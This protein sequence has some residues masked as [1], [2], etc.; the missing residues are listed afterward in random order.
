[1]DIKTP[2]IT[3]YLKNIANYD[4]NKIQVLK[5]VNGIFKWVDE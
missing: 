1:M 2:H 3:A 4:V 5:N